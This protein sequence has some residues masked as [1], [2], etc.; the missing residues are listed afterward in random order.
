MTDYCQVGN[1]STSNVNS[2]TLVNGTDYKVKVVIGN[3]NTCFLL[4]NGA[5]K[6]VGGGTSG[7]LGDNNG[8]NNTSLVTV[9]G[10]DGTGGQQASSFHSC[11]LKTDGTA[12]C[13]GWNQAY[14]FHNGEDAG[15]CERDVERRSSAGRQ[16]SHLC[17]ASKRK[18]Y[19]LG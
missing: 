1:G 8:T 19:V 11:F 3:T 16:Q 7:Q 13:A 2:P 9:S 5:I 14:Q 18:C 6:C 4:Q 17:S 10:F 12:A 15:Q